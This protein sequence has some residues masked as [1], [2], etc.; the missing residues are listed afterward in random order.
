MDRRHRKQISIRFAPE[1]FE[2]L[3][4]AEKQTGKTRTQIIE[5]CIV[6]ELAPRGK[7][8]RAK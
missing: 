6:A 5:N 3:D 2:L 4:S 7:K 1:T 8:G